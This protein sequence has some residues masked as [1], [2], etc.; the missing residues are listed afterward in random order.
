MFDC[1]LLDDELIHLKANAKYKVVER[2]TKCGIV[3]GLKNEIPF[4][5]DLKHQTDNILKVSLDRDDYYFIFPTKFNS[6]FTTKFLFQGKEVVISLS[7]K[8]TVTLDGVLI[9][10]QNVENL[11]YSH[12]EI[13]KNMCFIYFNGDRNFVI[14]L[15]DESLCFADYYDEFNEHEN[16][17][18]LCVSFK[19]L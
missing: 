10:E 12:Y 2:G 18:F 17:K 6:F 3:F 15:K 9:C 16:E 13:N 4:V 5:L 14:I 8:I 7:H 11:N 1:F 19:I